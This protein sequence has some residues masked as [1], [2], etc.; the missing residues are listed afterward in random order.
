[1]EVEGREAAACSLTPVL[2]HLGPFVLEH[3]QVILVQILLAKASK[4]LLD[5]EASRTAG[6]VRKEGA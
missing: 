5:A 1:M 6:N 2:H 4:L 3:T